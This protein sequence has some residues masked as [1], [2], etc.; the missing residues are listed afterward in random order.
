ML[1]SK[2]ESMS[3]TAFSENEQALWD[4]FRSGDAVCTDLL[5]KKYSPLV[6]SCA[7]SFFL[8]GGETED[9]VQEGMLA[10]LGA[11][12]SYSSDRGS[13]FP[14]YATVCIRNRII[15]TV[16]AYSGGRDAL[17]HSHSADLTDIEPEKHRP[18]LSAPDPEDLL[19]RSEE[20]D[21]TL[22]KLLDSLTKL[23]K[24]ILSDYLSGL[25]YHQIAERC[26]KTPKSVDNSIQRIRKKMQ[27][28]I[29]NSD[30]SDS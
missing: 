12:H 18:W 3:K 15:D 27:A 13:S 25:S 20:A 17:D 23:E 14:S 11:M 24:A 22:R 26:G 4:G 21:H 7:R 19:I 28:I 10:L 9:L 16:K 6:L 30:N 8:T 29:N 2:S 1:F 5:L